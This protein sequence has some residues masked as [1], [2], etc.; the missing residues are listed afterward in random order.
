M[1]SRSNVT[2]TVLAKDTAMGANQHVSHFGAAKAAT[3]IPVI[4]GNFP[5]SSLDTTVWDEIVV[6]GGTTTVEDGVGKL[7]T[8]TNSAG[9]VKLLSI[10]QGIFEAGQVTVYQSGVYPG[11]GVADNIRRW[12]LMSAD[13]QDGLFFELNGTTFRVVARKAGSDTAVASASFNGDTSFT[14]GASNN[15]YRIHYSAGRALFQRA[16][17][18]NI[19]TLHT[20]VDSALPL[21]DD[22]DLGL[23]YENTNSGNTTDVEMR[24][25]GA[26]SSV[27]GD[28]RRF[29]E[30]GAQIVA[31][32]GT[33]VARSKVPGYEIL[34]QDGRNPDVDIGTAEDMW[35]G[36]GDYTGFD[37]DDNE[38]I[39][40]LSSSANDAG[41]Q[42]SSGTATGGSRTTL[43]DSGADFVTTDGVATGDVLVNTTRGTHG[44]VSAVTATQIT[45]HRMVTGNSLPGR[46]SAGDSYIVVTTSGTGAALVRLD[47]LLNASYE[48][49]DPQY[50]VLNGTT[51]VTVSGD[52]M[53][54][55]QAEVILAGSGGTNAGSITVRQKT[56]TANVFAVMPASTGNTVIGACTIPVGKTALLK[57][58]RVAITRANGSAGSA[59]ITLRVRRQGEIFRAIRNFE[60][61]TGASTEFRQEGVDIIREC[62][63]IKFRVDSVSDNNT[64][65]EG[66]FEF[67]LVEE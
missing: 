41:S 15:T 33:E 12:G 63:D 7:N 37:A 38:N 28:L 20:M 32:F 1:S 19:V 9:S 26:S 35:S 66:A 64:I 13:E 18:G 8:G 36:G 40:V 55:A 45:V 10:Q 29:N 3:T 56:T 24:V 4:K 42:I 31:D 39:E 49:Q 16:S 57:R 25:R 54:C 11:T 46:N 21:V 43:V 34:A 65:A 48:E 14:P 27:F 67:Y 62:S 44:V 17:S 52:F 2:Q 22:L 59:N 51:G 23:Y 61:Q 60:A 53:R 6:S 47:K 50:A 5:G 58:V 30:G